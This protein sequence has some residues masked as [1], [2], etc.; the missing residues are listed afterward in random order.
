MKI[1]NLTNEELTA[2]L[3]S[4][5]VKNA[6]KGLSLAQ[7][8]KEELT[9]FIS[10]YTGEAKE[11]IIKRIE[12]REQHIRQNLGKSIEDKIEALDEQAYREHQNGDSLI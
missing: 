1:D 10:K 12:L 7:S 5:A 9:D 4:H 11:E 2:L 3:S 6:I 8:L